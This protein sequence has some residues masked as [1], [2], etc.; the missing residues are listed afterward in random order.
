MQIVCTCAPQLIRRDGPRV[1]P[2]WALIRPAT[3]GRA[4][5]GPR[6]L[7][8][9]CCVP[10]DPLCQLGEFSS[11][12]CILLLAHLQ[13]PCLVSPRTSRKQ[14]NFFVNRTVALCFFLLSLLLFSLFS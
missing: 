7:A 3:E 4:P 5:P 9:E 6:L 8:E 10:K 14:H 13:I 1:V 2:P 12:F 11:S